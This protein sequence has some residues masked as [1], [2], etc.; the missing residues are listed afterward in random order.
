MKNINVIITYNITSMKKKYFFLITFLILKT[1]SCQELDLQ[2]GPTYS[3]SY[4]YNKEF[5]ITKGIF[6]SKFEFLILSQFHFNV[7][8][9]QGDYY[10]L[11]FKYSALDLSYTR[12]GVPDPNLRIQ[13]F[14]SRIYSNLKDKFIFAKLKKDGTIYDIIG[15]DEVSSAFNSDMELLKTEYNIIYPILKE[16]LAY[17]LQGTEIF[18]QNFFKGMD[19]KI[20]KDYFFGSLQDTKGLLRKPSAKSK[21]YISYREKGLVKSTDAAFSSIFGKPVS[22]SKPI[23]VST[24]ETYLIQ[25]EILNLRTKKYSSSASFKD[26]RSNYKFYSKVEEKTIFKSS[27]E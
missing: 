23:S 14:I 13:K 9:D 21:K 15:L 1:I 20:E 4:Y 10:L 24:K 25:D 22:T 6:E 18:L 2:V 8:R 19:K 17:T 7:I 3:I 12:D 26:D 16:G 5:K 27:M 11:R